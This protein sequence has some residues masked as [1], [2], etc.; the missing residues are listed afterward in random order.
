MPS[1]NLKVTVNNSQFKGL[2]HYIKK[3]CAYIK[4]FVY[5]FMMLN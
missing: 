4:D 2:N 5:N 3:A 1:N